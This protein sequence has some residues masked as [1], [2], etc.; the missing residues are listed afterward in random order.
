MPVLDA[1][2]D[3]YDK[4]RDG[5]ITDR[6][7]VNLFSYVWSMNRRT[8]IAGSMINNNKNS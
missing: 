3:F 5:Y 6:E 8:L 4:D 2:F 1:L 7:A